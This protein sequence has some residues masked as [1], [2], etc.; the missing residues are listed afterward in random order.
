MEKN[1]DNIETSWFAHNENTIHLVDKYLDFEND[2]ICWIELV[3]NRNFGKIINKCWNKVIDNC[4][5]DDLNELNCM[6]RFLNNI[7]YL[8][9]NINKICW[10]NISINP[11]IFTYDY[12]EIKKVKSKINKDFIEWVWKPDNMD[13]WKSLK[14]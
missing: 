3:Q 14:L 9:K 7:E 11:I 13:K 5:Y 4:Y 2:D 8:E 10:V 6:Y 12:K 1:I